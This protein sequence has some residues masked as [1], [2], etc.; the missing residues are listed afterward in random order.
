MILNTAL[1]GEGDLV[2]PELTNDF[3]LSRAILGA[4][5]ENMKR[6]DM[7]HFYHPKFK[8]HIMFYDTRTKW[9]IIGIPPLNKLD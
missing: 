2:G 9:Q 3:F 5:R 6:G 1:L 4:K 7:P 8:I